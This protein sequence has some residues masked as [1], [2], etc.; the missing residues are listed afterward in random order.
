[1]SLSDVSLIYNCSHCVKITYHPVEQS[2]FEDFCLT[3]K[4]FKGLLYQSAEDDDWRDFLSPLRRY[5]FE[6]CASPL[7]F[8][9]ASVSEYIDLTN[10]GKRIS[11]FQIVYPDLFLPAS[12]LFNQLNN[13]SK[14]PLNPLLSTCLSIDKANTQKKIALLL[15][16]SRLIPPVEELI[17]KINLLNPFKV[18]VASQLRSLISYD[19]II[20]IGSPYWFPQYI[21]TAPR[22]S[23]IDIVHYRWIKS[24]WKEE[25]VF[26]GSVNF[27]Q[28]PI[29]TET[30]N[31]KK[32]VQDKTNSEIVT[33]Q[34]SPK[35]ILMP[36]IEWSDISQKITQLHFSDNDQEE[37]EAKMFLLE[38]ST[39][40]V[41]LDIDAKAFIIDLQEEV[42]SRVK[43]IFVTDIEADMFILLRTGGG[44]D[45]IIPV[46]NRIL[47]NSGKDVEK[48]RNLQQEWKDR[49]KLAVKRQG[50]HLVSQNLVKQG[51]KLAKNEPNVRNWM[52]DLSIKP[53][54][55]KD[56][57]AILKFVGLGDRFNE[58]NEVAY[59]LAQAHRS[60]GKHIR[61]LLLQKVSNSDLTQLEQLGSMEFEL[62]KADEGSMAAFRVVD[63]SPEI[64][65]IPVSQTGHIFKI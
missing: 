53:R 62:E 29:K 22:T 14:S 44:G 48:I 2:D 49:L 55:E 38:G 47:R 61:K 5:Q 41:F 45:Y 25:S 27:S 11:R 35:D 34:L 32:E 64:H 28:S 13:L 65:N 40:A 31:V 23:E 36:T 58:F 7:P 6:L 60:A 10:L 46:A 4:K 19:K 51:S 18:I 50:L 39:S 59:L 12:K 43:R 8:N 42:N 33:A 3:L 20:I 17:S 21:I 9:T 56:F 15:K 24:K 52:S 37:I 16:E 63:S 54:D 1:M 26:L 30:K 57:A